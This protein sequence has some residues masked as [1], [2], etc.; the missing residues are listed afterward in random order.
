MNNLT[1]FEAHII[2]V[3][4]EAGEE[5]LA[6]LVNT[7]TTGSESPDEI[8][9]IEFALKALLSCDL[10]QLA[11]L[12]DKASLRWNPLRKDHSL[13]MLENLRSLFQ[14]SGTDE[15]WRRRAGAPEVEVL[16]TE[17]GLKLA[18]KILS[19]CGWDF[20]RKKSLH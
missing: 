7:V 4:E 20:W 17:D 10:V 11:K 3:L 13:V 8:E 14:W 12:R 9:S 2:A 16:L 19:D 5:E 15:R 18:R 6:T 1:D